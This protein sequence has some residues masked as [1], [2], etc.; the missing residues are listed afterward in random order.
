VDES[1][2]PLAVRGTAV[3]FVPGASGLAAELGPDSQLT[4]TESPRLDATTVTIEVMVNPHAIGDRMTIVE[5]PGQYSLQ[6]LGSGSAMCSAA[7]GYALESA[8]VRAGRWTRLR[9]VFDGRNV[10]LWVDGRQAA[11]GPSQPLYTDRGGGLR[12]GW[13]DLP[14]RPLV[15]LVDE[16]RVWRGAQAP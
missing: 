11:E 1:P 15:G 7:G 16:L 5:N 2:V 13:D 4:V 6:V 3:R 10:R 14:S 12:I 9:C 8:A